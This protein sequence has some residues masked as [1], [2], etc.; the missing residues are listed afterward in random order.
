MLEKTLLEKMQ[1]AHQSHEV[2]QYIYYNT[3]KAEPEEKEIASRRNNPYYNEG[4]HDI[5]YVLCK[6]VEFYANKCE[7]DT[8]KMSLRLGLILNPEDVNEDT[9][10]KED[11]KPVNNYVRFYT[12][13]QYCYLNG[14]LTNEPGK[15]LYEPSRQGYVSYN[16]LM[17]LLDKSGVTFNGPKSYESFKNAILE[18]KKFD[19]SIT[20][21]LT[22]KKEQ[23][24]VEEVVYEEEKEKEKEPEEKGRSFVKKIFRRR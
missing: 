16:K 17:R 18:G 6:G 7:F 24:V 1:E 5:E 19:L 4:D 11:A 9:S 15:S 3:G 10:I 8:F 14:E 2:G 20:A 13:E 22:K 23:E 12:G 21:D